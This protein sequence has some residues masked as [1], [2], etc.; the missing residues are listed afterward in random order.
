[1]NKT[2]EDGNL[3]GG[4]A[5]LGRLGGGYSQD[6]PSA[7]GAHGAVGDRSRRTDNPVRPASALPFASN[8]ES[9]SI[10]SWFS[11]L[12]LDLTD[13]STTTWSPAITRPAST[14]PLPSSPFSKLASSFFPLET[15]SVREEDLVEDDPAF[16][17][18]VAHVLVWFSEDLTPQQRLATVYTL[19][20][21]LSKWQMQY[22]Q[23]FLAQEL[24]RGPD[25]P[26]ALRLA[27]DSWEAPVVTPDPVR[28][29]PAFQP[30]NWPEDF[31]QGVPLSARG[32]DDLG[33]VNS[34]LFFSDLSGWFRLHRLHKYYQIF[35]KLA[36]DRQRILSMTEAD[37][38]SHGV[39]ALGA[40]RKFLR[41]FEA[42]RNCP[43]YK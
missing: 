11:S 40:R 19:A 37:L 35:Q 34:A 28:T 31:E 24:Q 8:I 6:E 41:L 12:K 38:E 27:A 1:M 18:D 43:D 21:N 29:A 10:D 7:N 13:D 15:P 23:K 20:R 4:S 33:P 30:K 2:R 42:I 32:T 16:K 9:A 22:L 3:G 39:S 17:N 25:A 14:S 26:S 5:S 36:S